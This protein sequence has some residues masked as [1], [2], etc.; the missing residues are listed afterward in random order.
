MIFGIVIL[1]IRQILGLG[2][3]C[4]P[5]AVVYF[6][7]G[8]LKGWRKGFFI[9]S[10]EM[11]VAGPWPGRTSMPPSRQRSFVKMPCMRAV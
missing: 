5:A 11:V 2:S 8:S 7:Y 1:K 10:S 9:L 6:S 4:M 3:A